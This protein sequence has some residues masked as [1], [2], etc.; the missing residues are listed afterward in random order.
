MEALALNIKLQPSNKQ[1]NTYIL[2]ESVASENSFL[3]NK[4]SLIERK[5]ILFFT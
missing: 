3:T 1:K 4:N 2:K 5:L